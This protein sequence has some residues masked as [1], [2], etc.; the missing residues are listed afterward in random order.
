MEVGRYTLDKPQG[1]KIRDATDP[2]LY[3]ILKG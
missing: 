2:I 1:F 3:L